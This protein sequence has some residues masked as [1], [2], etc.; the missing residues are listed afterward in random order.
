M[1]IILHDDAVAEAAED[2]L[3]E[4]LLMVLR[5]RHHGVYPTAPMTKLDAY[6]AR[7]GWSS[8]WEAAL[9]H[10]ARELLTQRRAYTIEVVPKGLADAS[11]SPPRLDASDAVRLLRQPLYVMVENGR[12]DGELLRALAT[13]DERLPQ[14]D[15]YQREGIIELENGGGLP[16]MQRRLEMHLHNRLQRLRRFALFDSD[17]VVPGQPSAASNALTSWCSPAN[18]PPRVGHHQLQRRAAENYLPR[19]ALLTWTEQ[20]SDLL[21]R[22]G[23]AWAKLTDPQRH[24]YAMREGLTK[25]A[26]NPVAATFFGNLQDGQ[27]TVLQSGFGRE[28]RDLFDATNPDWERWMREDGQQAEVRVLFQKLLERV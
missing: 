16:E 25:D 7:R 27:R 20:Q 9:D 10:G 14:W 6:L 15:R 22:R 21:K 12:N 5:G 4:L 17:A 28:V 23:R 11:C 26:G 18:K 13:L 24:H 3:D 2:D 1:R 8:R 19:P